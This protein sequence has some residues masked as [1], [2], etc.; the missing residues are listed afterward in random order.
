M[1]LLVHN[2]LSSSTFLC[3]IQRQNVRRTR[4][5]MKLTKHSHFTGAII[6]I[7]CSINTSFQFT[8]LEEFQSNFNFFTYKIIINE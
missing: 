7:L 5:K 4:Q 2:G 3:M 8:G 6:I 1:Y